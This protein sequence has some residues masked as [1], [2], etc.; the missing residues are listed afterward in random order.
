MN[1][2]FDGKNIDIAFYDPLSFA[3]D[4]LIW[5]CRKILSKL[6]GYL[7]IMK[8]ELFFSFQIALQTEFFIFRKWTELGKLLILDKRLN[9]LYLAFSQP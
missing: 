9:H 3:D 8:D 2:K 6:H 4:I 7:F 5:M 1:R